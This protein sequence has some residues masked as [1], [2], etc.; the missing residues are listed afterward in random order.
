MTL[1]FLHW[2]FLKLTVWDFFNMWMQLMN[3][4]KV[5]L[6]CFST[7]LWCIQRTVS[8]MN[9]GCQVQMLSLMI[10]FQLLPKITKNSKNSLFSSPI[11]LFGMYYFLFLWIILEG[12]KSKYIKLKALFIIFYFI[13]IIINELRL[14]KILVWSFLLK[15]FKNNLKNLAIFYSS[16]IL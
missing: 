11:T 8:I 7:S 1:I 10:S 12:D 16:I 9:Y 6:D 15:K 13:C 4:P 5:L 3:L 2:W 14:L